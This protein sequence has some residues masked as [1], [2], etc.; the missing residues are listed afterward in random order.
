MENESICTSGIHLYSPK[1]CRLM[2]LAFVYMI[3]VRKMEIA[4]DMSRAATRILCLFSIFSATS[5]DVAVWKPLQ[6][7]DRQIDMRGSTSW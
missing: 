1:I 2:K 6:Q 7:S 4:D 5:F 3:N